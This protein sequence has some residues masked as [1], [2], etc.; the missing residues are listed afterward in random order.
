MRTGPFVVILI[1]A[2]LSPTAAAAKI[3]VPAD[4]ATIQAAVDAAAAGDVIE[5][6]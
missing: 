3:K 4:H 2:S 5:I 6:S 1:A